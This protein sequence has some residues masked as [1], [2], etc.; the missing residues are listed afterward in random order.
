MRFG[1]DRLKDNSFRALQGKR[2][3][4]F[5]NLPAVDRDLVS[6]Y[7]VLRQAQD[8]NLAALFGPEHGFAGMAADGEH[9]SSTTDPRTGLPVYSLYGETMHPTASMLEGINVMVCDLQDIGV[10]YY[11]FLWTLTHVLEAC[12]AH[13]AAVMILDRP[14]P[15]GATVDGGTLDPALASLVGRFPIPIQHGMTIGEMAQLVNARWNP[16]QADVTVIP[17]DGWQRQQRWD[18]IGRAFVPPSLNMP[19][20]VTALHYPGACLVEGTILSEGRG[21]PLPFE[22]VGAP[23]IDAWDLAAALHRLELPGVR[24]RPHL[25]KPNASKYKG[26]TCSGVQVHITDMTDYRPL[27]VWLHVIQTIQQLY[28]D[29]FAWL[30]QE[31]FSDQTASGLQHFDRLIGSAEVRSQ[32]DSGELVDAI[33][34][35][36]PAFHQQFRQDAAPYL[37]YK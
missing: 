27:L 13:G 15:L 22:V 21:T 5:T 30:P 1:I 34:A 8:V 24:F 7:D 35:G 16:S 6:T 10:R 25:F 9:V 23:F 31:T 19:H 17:C 28:P 32:L 12:G 33:I 3:G 4:L 11:T 26:E 37:L 29:D 20:F 14:N 2:V 36:W 18:S